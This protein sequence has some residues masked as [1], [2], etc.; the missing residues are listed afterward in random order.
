TA[1]KMCVT[2]SESRSMERSLRQPP[3][4]RPSERL[5]RLSKW[6]L[7]LSS[8]D[9]AAVLELIGLGAEG[10]LFGVLCVFDGVR[11]VEDDPVKGDFEV[12]YAKAGKRALLNGPHVSL[13]D[14]YQSLR[15]E[16]I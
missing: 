12:Y 7:K 11:A 14:L 5:L 10:A 6:F 4:R 2:D 1:L 16:A 8:D 13:H 15:G 9:Q 3:G